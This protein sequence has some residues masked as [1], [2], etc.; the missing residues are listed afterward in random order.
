MMRTFERCRAWLQRYGTETNPLTWAA[1]EEGGKI[2]AGSKRLPVVFAALLLLAL[3]AVA[4]DESERVR[5]RDPDAE[6][7]VEL[8]DEAIARAREI[9]PGAVLRQVDLADADS[10][11][12]FRL[13]DASSTRAVVLTAESLSQPSGGFELSLPESSPLVGH[14]A[15]GFTLRFLEV[16][17]AA[18]VGAAGK[19]WGDCRPRGLT[20][21][22]KD[23]ALTW[24]VF[25]D[26]PVGV[27]SATVDA[28]TGLFTPSSAPPARIPRTATPV[29]R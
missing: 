13:T 15:T 8:S 14:P 9:V 6:A 10:G 27:V 22:G 17:P 2:S 3:S 21:V 23:D 29:A 25:C 28:Q 18:V 1:H 11:P 12:I 4:C 5:D 16:G 7:L 20:L 19:F 24:F 26:T